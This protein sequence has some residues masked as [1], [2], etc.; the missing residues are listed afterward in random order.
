MRVEVLLFLVI[1]G[2]YWKT[3]DL[4]I[5]FTILEISEWIFLLSCE[6]NSVQFC[7]VPVHVCIL[8]DEKADHLAKE[9]PSKQPMKKGIPH[10]D[11]IPGIRESIR[12]TWQFQI[13]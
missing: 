5:Q 6:P 3:L 2:V 10:S 1:Q 7:W 12:F 9:G 4:L 8:S 11:Y 13:R